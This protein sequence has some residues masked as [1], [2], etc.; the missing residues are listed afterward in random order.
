LRGCTGTSMGVND[1]SGM[2]LASNIAVFG[3]V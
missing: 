1:T 3:Q 2:V